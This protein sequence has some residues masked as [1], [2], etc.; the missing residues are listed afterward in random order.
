[1]CRECGC[2]NPA[3]QSTAEHHLSRETIAPGR[4][5]LSLEE[6]ILSPNDQ[7]ASILKDVFHSKQICSL[8]MMSSPGSG[9]TA[10]IERMLQHMQTGSLRIGVIVG[11]LCTDRDAQRLRRYSLTPTSVIQVTTGT[12]CHLTAAMVATAAKELDL[13]S[14]DLVV[15]ENVGNLVCPAIFNLGEDLRVVVT[16]VT[17]GEDKPYKYPVAFKAADIVLLNKIDLAEAVGFDREQGLAAIQHVAPQAMIF[18]ISARTGAGLEQWHRYLNEHLR[19]PNRNN[20]SSYY[21][22]DTIAQ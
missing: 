22:G 6:K 18:E 11:D 5:I 9:K 3:E 12:V 7:V 10:L 8:T 14:I 17:E 15:I 21:K 20:S 19:L 4:T 16:S 2:H 13:D 1:M